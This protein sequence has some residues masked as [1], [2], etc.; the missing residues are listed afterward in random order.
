MLISNIVD[1]KMVTKSDLRELE[2]KLAIRFGGMLA[3]A[4][5]ALAALMAIIK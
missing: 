2:Y 4:V 1:E 3:V 5:A